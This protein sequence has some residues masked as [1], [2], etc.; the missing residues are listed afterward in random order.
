MYSFVPNL[1]WVTC[2][3]NDLCQLNHDL[4]KPT[5]SSKPNI[6]LVIVDDLGWN[7]IG[8]NNPEIKT[9]FIDKLAFEGVRLHN[10]YVQPACSPSRA[11]LLT[12][13][14]QV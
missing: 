6:L 3:G 4:E 2:V 10:H 11:Q 13:K 1:F 12:G 8:Y 14:Y 5:I 7:D 9:P